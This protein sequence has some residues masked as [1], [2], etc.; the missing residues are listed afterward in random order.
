[1]FARM[2]FAA[3]SAI[4]YMTFQQFN[5]DVPVETTSRTPFV[6]DD[7]EFIVPFIDELESIREEAK[8]EEQTLGNNVANVLAQ[9]QTSIS[10]L[11]RQQGEIYTVMNNLPRVP[12]TEEIESI[13][14]GKFVSLIKE[15]K[16]E[17]KAEVATL[18]VSSDSECA[19]CAEK[20]ESIIKRLEA[21]E[22]RCGLVALSNSQSVGSVSTGQGSQGGSLSYSSQ[23]AYS[24]P[25]SEQVMYSTGTGNGGS[26]GGSTSYAPQASY[27][28]AQAVAV[29]P[30]TR[31]VRV[32]EPM[33]RRQVSYAEVPDTSV[34]VQSVVPMAATGSMCYTDPVTG[35]TTCPQ[36]A[37][38]MPVQSTPSGRRGLGLF[39]R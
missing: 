31:T 27:M 12:S 4:S 16:E 39:R 9:L 19:A 2:M 18:S 22:L 37:Q 24:Y 3:L 32:V 26:N 38:S 5:A 34:A 10:T 13:A 15:A 33:T 1:M 30:R 7:T 23:V 8:A 14:Q 17:I 6:T 25:S 29:E 28:P 20:I 21:L 11:S 35:Q 36:Q